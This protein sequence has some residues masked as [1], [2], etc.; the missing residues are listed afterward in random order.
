M[1]AFFDQHYA[2]HIYYHISSLKNFIINNSSYYKDVS[3]VIAI[4]LLG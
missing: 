4:E 1:K 3:T 2:L